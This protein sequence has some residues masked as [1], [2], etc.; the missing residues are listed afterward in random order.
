MQKIVL[1]SKS[2]RRKELLTQIGLDFIVDVSE[3]DED[4][5]KN[6]APQSLVKKLSRVKAEKVA[7]RH[8]N[9]IIIAADTLVVLGKE[10][11]GKPKDE[12]DAVRIL[13][14]LSG[15]THTVITGFTILDSK[16]KRQITEIVK[17]KLKFKELSNQEIKDYVTTKEPMDKAGGYGIQGKASVFIERIN[18]DFSNIV[19]L[20]I[21]SLCKALKK[22][23]I[24]ITANWQYA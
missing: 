11:I 21:F 16:T 10:L 4:K 7:K 3:I 6:L 14:K 17:S 13:K 8:K 24:N 1:A 20:P 18:G 9:A 23:G 5:F 15:K 22:F 12:K 2:P 19:G